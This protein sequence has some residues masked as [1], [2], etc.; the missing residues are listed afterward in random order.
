M[1]KIYLLLNIATLANDILIPLSVVMGVSVNKIN[2][3]IRMVDFLRGY[4]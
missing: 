3:S 2:L 4:D 1:Y